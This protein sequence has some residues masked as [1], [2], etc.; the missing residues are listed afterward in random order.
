MCIPFLPEERDA[1]PDGLSEEQLAIPKGEEHKVRKRDVAPSPPRSRVQTQLENEIAEAI[2]PSLVQNASASNEGSGEEEEPV[3]QASNSAASDDRSLSS[4][5]DM[6]ADAFSIVDSTA[7]TEKASGGRRKDAQGEGGRKAVGGDES[8][9]D[10]E[11]EEHF[12][13]PMARVG[14]ESTISTNS[15]LSHMEEEDFLALDGL[16]TVPENDVLDTVIVPKKKHDLLPKLP[17]SPSRR[18][19]QSSL[20]KA[21]K[22]PKGKSSKV[23]K[24][25]LKSLSVLVYGKRLSRRNF[26]A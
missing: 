24:D 14:S 22:S 17:L 5:Y 6:I 13:V 20:R 15:A 3:E 16:D 1:G 26:E 10:N 9:L 19:T 12:V 2:A 23:L 11:V 18:F 25:N 21:R 4:L 8:S 7:S